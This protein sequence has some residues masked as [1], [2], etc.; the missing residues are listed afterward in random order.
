MSSKERIRLI[1]EMCEMA[2]EWL[3]TFGALQQIPSLPSDLH[4]RIDLL[5]DQIKRWL[6]DVRQMEESNDCM[7]AAEAGRRDRW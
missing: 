4:H 3:R 6:S 1:R 5:R 2:P 7:P